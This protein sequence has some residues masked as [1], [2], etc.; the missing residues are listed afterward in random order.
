MLRIENRSIAAAGEKRRH[1]TAKLYIQII[2]DVFTHSASFLPSNRAAIWERKSNFAKLWEFFDACCETTKLR[3]EAQRDSP[4]VE[5]RL[6]TF[7][8]VD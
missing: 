8:M 4:N 1:N 2:V 5:R 3:Q 6:K 7:G